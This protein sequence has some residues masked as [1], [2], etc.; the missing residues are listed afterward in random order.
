MVVGVTKSGD[1]NWE[2]VRDWDV[3]LQ[4]GPLADKPRSPALSPEVRVS[5]GMDGAVESAQMYLEGR[6]GALEL[7]FTLP[8]V[9]PL[10]CLVPG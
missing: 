9:E 3:I 8:T 5:H 7:P 6:L 1:G 2:L 10:C 4:L